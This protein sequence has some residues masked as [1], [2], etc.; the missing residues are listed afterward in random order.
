MIKLSAFSDEAGNSIEEQISALKRNGIALMELRSIDGK[1]VAE[2]TEEE[3][4]SYQKQLEE[5]GISVW[6]LG[7]PIGKIN[8]NDDFDKE[9]EK[10]RALLEVG[11]ILGAKCIRLFSFYGC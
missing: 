3:A 6:S 5:N 10:L 9:I 11:K 4:K 2:F 1:N 8:I 7:S